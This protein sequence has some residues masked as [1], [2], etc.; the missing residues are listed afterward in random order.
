MEVF[1]LGKYEVQLFFSN[2][3]GTKGMPSNRSH[4][5]RTGG[6]RRLE[7]F[8]NPLKPVN[9]S[10]QLLKSILSYGLEREPFPQFIF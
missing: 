5:F 8:Y 3:I 4:R 10:F 6:L 1:I 2:T 9:F 7:L